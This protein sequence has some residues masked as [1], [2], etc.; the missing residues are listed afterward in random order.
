MRDSKIL[1][2]LAIFIIYDISFD[3]KFISHA[4]NLY[5]LFSTVYQ[6]FLIVTDYFLNKISNG[7]MNIE[8]T[9]NIIQDKLDI[10]LKPGES[11]SLIRKNNN[12]IFNSVRDIIQ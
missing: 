1:E 10:V 2:T 4:K 11:K 8:R 12:S 7:N 6:N 3:N 9:I 5:N